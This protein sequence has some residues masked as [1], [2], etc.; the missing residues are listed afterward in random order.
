[1]EGLYRV[2]IRHAEAG[3]GV[4]VVTGGSFVGNGVGSPGIR[5]YAAAG[6]GLLR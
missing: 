4:L 5:A 3:A 1:M 6:A 2:E